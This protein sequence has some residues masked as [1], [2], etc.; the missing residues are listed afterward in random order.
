VSVPENDRDDDARVAA[1]SRSWQSAE[2][3][4]YPSVMVRPDAYESALLLVRALADRLADIRTASALA[5]AFDGAADLVAG[6][7][8]ATGIPARD[9]DLALV[10]GAAFNLRHREIRTMR[11]REQA[12]SRIA[13]AAAQ[14]DA[15]VVLFETGRPELAMLAPYRRL[16]MRRADGFGL[17]ASISVNLE[18]G[19]PEYSIERVQLDPV[20]GDW[21]ADASGPVPVERFESRDKWETAL[22]EARTAGP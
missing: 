13:G 19:S 7:V 14:G 6:A 17:H 18:T 9:L 2:D 15:W 4:L 21:L 11:Q 5:E 10:A 16:E 8:R 1:L 3:R 22:A 20:T 12:K